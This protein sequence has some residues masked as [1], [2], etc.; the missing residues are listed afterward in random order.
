VCSYLI[1]VISLAGKRQSPH[2]DR[3]IEDQTLEKWD[4]WGFASQSP[5]SGFYLLRYP[6]NSKI[7]SKDKE[8]AVALNGR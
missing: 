5:I 2:K 4:G 1:C 7:L 6:H 3:N 8:I